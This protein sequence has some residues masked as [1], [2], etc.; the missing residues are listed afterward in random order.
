MQAMLTQRGSWLRGEP[1]CSFKRQIRSLPLSRRS[2]SWRFLQPSQR[3][4]KAYADS[5]WQT[6]QAS[7]R[8][9]PANSVDHSPT[10]INNIHF[11][12]SPF[13]V[14]PRA[15]RSCISLKQ[16]RQ[17]VGFE[18]TTDRIHLKDADEAWIA[19]YRA[20]VKED[21]V[22]RSRSSKIRQAL[23]QAHTLVFSRLNRILDRWL[24]GRSQSS[25]QPPETSVVPRPN[26]QEETL[27]TRRKVG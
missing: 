16:A 25:A 26:P 27:H 10:N 4:C 9:A 23:N 1:T 18:M 2:M 13:G 17:N 14:V 7:A 22:K 20:A 6:L 19:K 15:V 24:P 3:Y 21:P 8:V 12:I 5:S 11:V